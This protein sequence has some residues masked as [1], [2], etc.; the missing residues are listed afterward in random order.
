LRTQPGIILRPD[1]NLT[2]AQALLE[3][4]MADHSREI[5]A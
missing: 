4:V 3:I 2:L 5:Q 1:P